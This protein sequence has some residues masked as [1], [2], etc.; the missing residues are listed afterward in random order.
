MDLKDAYFHL[1]V[2]EALRPFLRHK[3]GDQVWEYQAGPF[4]LN[5]M[6][7]LFQGVMKTFEKKWRQKGVEVYIYLDDILLIA[8]TPGL[9]E[10]NLRLVLQDLVDSGFKIN[11]KKSSLVPSQ[12][13]SHLGFV[14]NFQEGKLQLSP[15]KVKGIRKELG[16]FVTKSVMSKR[17]VAA[18]LGQIRANLL[19]MP[20]L[21][22]FTS[23]LVTFL[24]EKGS[25]PWESKHQLSQD[26]KQELATVRVLLDKWE[27]RPFVVKPTRV[28]HSDSSD[29][30]WGGIDPKTGQFV[31]E[32]WREQSL[33]HINVKEMMAAINTVQS[34]AKPAETVLLCVDNQV[35]FYYLQKGGGRKNPF[36]QLLQPFYHWLMSK[37]I[38]LQVKWVPSAQCLADPLSRWS[39]DR[40]DYS[41]DPTLF[42]QVQNFFLPW[43]TLETDLF[44]SP[45]NKKLEQFVSRWPHWQA[46][47]VDALQ[48]PLEN[49]GGLYANPPWSVIQ[50]FLARLRL[51]PQVPV[52]MVVPFWVSATWWPQLIKLRVPEAPCLK[53]N[54]YPG[55]FTNCWGEAMPPPRWPL[56]CLICSGKFWRGDKSKLPL[57]TTL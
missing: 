36:N 37:N 30:G 8:P 26:I 24:A 38:T 2:N 17:Q 34:L 55:M 11:Q 5:V 41:L 4:G 22:A 23:L 14:L 35:I 53:V 19:A 10:K 43:I 47:G 28:L 42:Q 40:G 44:A 29:N 18:I 25:A 39:Q 16:K 27:G 50:K 13:V 20:F 6:P 12:V 46:R 31:Q 57:L 21:R 52:L 54:P 7:Q 33:L 1:P 48:C 3:V 51:S 32:F 9:V 15:H 49:M 45:G 56:L